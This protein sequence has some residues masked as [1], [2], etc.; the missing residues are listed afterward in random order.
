MEGVTL[1]SK[2]EQVSSLKDKEAG[3]LGGSVV[4]RLPSAHVVVP[5][6]QTPHPAPCS[7]GSLL[8]PL[9]LPLLVFPLSLCLF[10]SNK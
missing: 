2:E 4:K 9:P 8:L 10:L 6:D 3:R 1:N 7:A 5:R